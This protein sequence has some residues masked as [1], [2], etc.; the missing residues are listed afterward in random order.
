MRKKKLQKIQ[1]EIEGCDVKDEKVLHAHH[2]IDRVIVG[3]SNHDYNLAI[4]CPT[5]HS[6]LHQTN[7]LKILGVFPST[8]PPQGRTLIYIL[9]G[10]CNVDGIDEA[11]FNHTPQQMKVY[12]DDDKE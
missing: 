5:H 3:T 9:D 10:K 4:I 12:Y 7:R 1:C 11:Y 2:I 6:M 8:R